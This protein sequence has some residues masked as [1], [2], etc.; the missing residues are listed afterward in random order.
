LKYHRIKITVNE[1]LSFDFT[2]LSFDICGSCI[3]VW[4]GILQ[5][6]NEERNIPHTQ[7]KRGR[8]NCVGHFLR[9]NCLLEHFIEEKIEGTGRRGRIRKQLLDDLEETKSY[10]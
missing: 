7:I 5:S 9:R 8:A 6:V 10:W 2:G 4:L 3:Y 1:Y